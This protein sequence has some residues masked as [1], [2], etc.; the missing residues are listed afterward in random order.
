MI[1]RPKIPRPTY[2]LSEVLK[3][4][5]DY[6]LCLLCRY[7]LHIDPYAR[8][9]RSQLVHTTYTN[10]YVASHI[11]RVLWL[12]CKENAEVIYTSR[13]IRAHSVYR[14]RVCFRHAYDDIS[15][16]AALP[17]PPI[18]VCRRIPPFSADKQPPFSRPTL[19][20]FNCIQNEKK[21][22]KPFSGSNGQLPCTQLSLGDGQ[23]I[24]LSNRA[25]GFVEST[26]QFACLQY[27]V[28]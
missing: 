28:K 22:L 5:F 8:A 13:Q 6:I 26:N 21:R 19:A 16:A 27:A 11:L 25:A 20:N 18:R 24:T 10:K 3:N 4:I 23:K 7:R 1:S 14:V 9:H 12:W 15:L 2:L 17:L